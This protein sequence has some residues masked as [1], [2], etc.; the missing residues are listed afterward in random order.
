MKMMEH[1]LFCLTL[2]CLILKEY[3]VN[4][5]SGVIRQGIQILTLITAAQS[6]AFYVLLQAE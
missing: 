1:F 2:K 5:V 6:F 3:S 4:S